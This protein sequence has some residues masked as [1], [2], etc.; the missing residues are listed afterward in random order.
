MNIN[1]G[2][3]LTAMVTPFNSNLEVDIDMVRDLAAYLVDENGSDGL[4]IL[5]TTSEV[6]T[7]SEDEKLSILE[8]VVDEVG[9]RATIVAG[10]GSYSTS[11]SIQL[12]QKA[13]KIGVD[14]IMLVVPYYNKPPQDGLYNHFKLIASQTKLPIMLYNVPSRTSRNL[15]AKT[16]GRLAKID[17]ICAVKE[18]S[19]DLPQVAEIARITSEDFYIYS[20]DDNLTLPILSVGGQGV[21]SVAS[22]LIG[23][24][25]KNM[26]SAFKQGDVQ[27]AAVLNNKLFP[28]FNGIFVNTN[29]IPVKAALRMS[30]KNVGHCRPPL[31]KLAKK[32]KE[33]LQTVLKQTELI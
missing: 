8:N 31:S 27:K 15:E 13:E 29:P 21:V 6:P 28:V 2:E 16:V 24:K 23:N 11:K 7:L 12:T 19:G 1:F 14:G 9:D 25:I 5:G 30:G 3:V 20:G 18:A 26:I 32:E 17:N 33:K 10:T 22:H 4:V